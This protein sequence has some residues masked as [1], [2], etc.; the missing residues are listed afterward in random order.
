MYKEGILLIDRCLDISITFPENPD[1][2]WDNACKMIQK[3]K[4]TRGEVLT[5]INCIQTSPQFVHDI[6]PPPSYEE[7]IATQVPPRTYNELAVALNNIESANYDR[8]AEIL[9]THDNV[10]MYYISPDGNVLSS[11]APQTLNI[12][13]VEGDFCFSVCTSSL[14]KNIFVIQGMRVLNQEPSCK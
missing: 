14:K 13:L 11:S 3:M 6:P 1:Q 10:Q 5:R 2:D 7:A 4:K 12:F 9:Y 8:N